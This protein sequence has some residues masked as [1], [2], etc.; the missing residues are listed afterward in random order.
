[1]AHITLE[2]QLHNLTFSHSHI[3]WH[4]MVYDFLNAFYRDEKFEI[5][6]SKI[7]SFDKVRKKSLSHSSHSISHSQTLTCLAQNCIRFY[8]CF[9]RDKK[10]EML[11]NKIGALDKVRQKSLSNPSHTLSHSDTLTCFAQNGV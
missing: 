5:L 11:G 7:R 1:M 6:G 9:H 8:E 10:F 3:V 2:S 4:Q